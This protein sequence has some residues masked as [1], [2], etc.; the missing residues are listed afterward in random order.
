MSPEEAQ[1][2][3]E[4]EGLLF[5]EQEKKRRRNVLEG[6]AM[7]LES[8]KNALLKALQAAKDKLV[9]KLFLPSL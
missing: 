2:L 7:D 9:L 1:R 8:E 6:L 4:E 3:F 5:E